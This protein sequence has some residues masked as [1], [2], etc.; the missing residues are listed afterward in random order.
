MTLTELGVRGMTCAS[1]AAHVTRA[2]KRV[3]GVD[4]AAV[5]LAT[6]RATI[7][8]DATVAPEALIAAV[9]RAGYGAT[10]ELDAD[11]EERERAEELR[12]KRTLLVLAVALATPTLALAMF[13][14]EFPGKGWLL[15][16][17]ALP[18]WAVVGW[19]FHRGALA[20]LAA[21]TLTMDTLVS[22][23]STA[24]FALSCYEAA[25]GHMTYFETS[26]AIVTLVF[27]GKYLEASARGKSTDAMR[28]L[29]ALRPQLAHRR[30]EDGSTHDV[31]VE[32]VRVGDTLVVP[33]GERIPVDGTI[34]EGRSA[35][36]RSI[37]TGESVPVDVEPGSP[38]EQGALNAD[39]ALTLRADA[40]GAGTELARIVAVVRKAQ[41]TTP[42]VQ[43]LADRIA[44]I[45]VPA[46][47]GIALV[48]F[49]G[50]LLTHHAWSDA[51]IA[52][53]AVLVVA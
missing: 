48:T 28:A 8:H 44:S 32:L 9:E 37:L 6:E 41:G 11:R 21:R 34:L 12:R 18:V 17:L 29:L 49:L 39:G 25:T 4:D 15:G 31:P 24:A 26:S 33:A 19:E 42:P 30:A 36:D 14:P 46:I 1:C 20:A 27:V 51:L 7:A 5:N 52:A 45:F 38:V 50:W 40:V 35:V 3:P 10:A 13:A 22:L 16:A 2:L 23:G 43:R 47:L 53:V